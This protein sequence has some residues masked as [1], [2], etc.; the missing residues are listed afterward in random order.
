MFYTLKKRK[1]GEKMIHETNRFGIESLSLFAQGFLS[2]EMLLFDI[3]T[4]GL[5]PASDTIYCIGCGWRDGGEA[6]VE[7][8]FAEDPGEESEVIESFFQLADTHPVL[9]TFNG[10]TFDIPFLKKRCAQGFPE[11]DEHIDLY[12]A[13][14]GMRNLLGLG[15]CKQKSVE[16][17]LGCSRED[18]YSGGELIE[19]YR[20]YVS[21][22]DPGLLAPIL[23]HNR[24]DVRGMFDLLSVLA[25]L[26][27]RDGRYE[28]TDVIE[29]ADGTGRRLGIKLRPDLPLPQSI[30]L[31]GEAASMILDCGAAMVSFPVR[32]G[33]LKHFFGDTENYYYLPEEDEAVH[34]SVGKYVES[35]HRTRA[36]KKN[37]YTKKECDYIDLPVQT[38]CS[39]LK[40]DYDDKGTCI[41]VP[42]GEEELRVL[43]DGYFTL[44][45]Q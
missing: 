25:Y 40:K 39:T 7:L 3:E 35:S 43:L 44:I 13:V 21:S 30:H 20:Q 12:R 6:C 45:T 33:T 9:V 11:Y 8:F 5:S 15:S 19:F 4:T 42:A 22:R 1:T 23:L 34:K 31:S 38:A 32:H 2:E 28:I 37:C 16:Q 10:T 29:E 17:F 24:E 18:K 36:T 41:E 14:R 27:F 26:Q